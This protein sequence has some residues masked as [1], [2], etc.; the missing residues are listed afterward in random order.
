MLTAAASSFF[1]PQPWRTPVLI[2]QGLL[3]LL[4]ITDSVMPETFPLKRLSAVIRAFVVL[5]AAAFCALA[6]SSYPR[7]NYGKRRAK[8]TPPY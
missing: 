6:A 5:T 7:K 1:L 4:A 8:R 2:A 3:Y